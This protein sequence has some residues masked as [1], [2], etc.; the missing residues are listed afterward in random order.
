MTVLDHRPAQTPVRNQGI[1]GACVG[2]AVA[3]AHE[4]M[5]PAALRS[6]EDVLWAAHRTGG[7]PQVEGTSV[8]FALTGLDTYRHAEETAWPFGNPPFPADRPTTATDAGRQAEL[9]AWQRL[10]S[11]SRDTIVQELNRG[12]ALVLTLA[13]VPGAW[14]RTGHVDAAAGRKFKGRHAV[15]AVG[16]VTGSPD[17]PDGGTL[18][19]NSWGADW[20][21]GGYGVVSDRYL[22]SYL[23][24]AHALEPAA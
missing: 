16:T 10:T 6:V 7:D 1:R 8:Q 14:P 12:A 5:R 3:A 9:P 20:G 19:K 2:F 18:I 13:V 15:V 22:A 11:P 24:V 23:T 4:W 17:V 21:L